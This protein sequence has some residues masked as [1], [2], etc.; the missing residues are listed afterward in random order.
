MIN[1][2][3]KCPCGEP[4]R[5]IGQRY[6]LKCHAEAEKKYREKKKEAKK[7]SVDPVERFKPQKDEYKAESPGLFH[8]FFSD[9]EDTLF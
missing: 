2:A 7:V 3:K 6:C 9:D 5:K 8:S 1:P 4:V